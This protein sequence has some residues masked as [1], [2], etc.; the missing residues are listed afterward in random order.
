MK[1]LRFYGKE[2]LRL[3]DLPEPVC[4]K[5]QVKVRSNQDE[6]H[7]EANADGYSSGR[8]DQLT[9]AS[10][11]LVYLH[12][13]T[14]GPNLIPVTPHPITLEKVPLTLGHEFS[15][16]IEEVGENVTDIKIG[17]RVVVQPIIYDK[18]C[19]ACEDGY[20]N[21]CFSNGFIGLSGWGGGLSDHCVAPRDTIFKLPDSVSL[22]I[23]AL[24]EPLAVA[25]HA[26]DMSPLK[27]GD[28]VLVLGGGPIGLAVIQ[29]LKARGVEK[30]IVSEVAETRKE[31][32]KSFGA[33]YVFDPRHDDIVEKCREISPG[34]GV[35]VVFDAAGAQAGL[36]VAIH[37][38]RARGTIVNIAV[39]KNPVKINPNDLVYK[40]RTY[41]GVATYV[42][43]D[44]A[45]VIDAIASGKIQPEMMITRKIKMDEIEEKGFKT[46]VN[47]KGSHVK[48]LVEV[49]P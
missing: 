46:L 2:D 49:H 25:W 24:V 48:I 38:T 11:G 47:D 9:S 44:F 33:H 1:A 28:A 19:G 4:G 27:P 6:M 37:A 32:A 40:E 26:V 22:E 14:G 23:G 39:W 15:G 7:I 5:D 10:A 13:Y 3:E 42:R 18:T 8:L 20:I 17:D 34:G 43:G 21:C 36:D 45:N 30:I 41:L 16:T 29:C 31:F 35:H 12:E